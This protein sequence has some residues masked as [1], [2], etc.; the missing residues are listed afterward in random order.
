MRT[1]DHVAIHQHRADA[2]RAGLLALRL[3]NGSGQSSFQKEVVD[4]VFK[5]AAKKHAAIHRQ[6]LAAGNLGLT[7]RVFR[8]TGICGGNGL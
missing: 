6:L 3:V 2:Y 1:C 7:N 8:R 5:H 4:A